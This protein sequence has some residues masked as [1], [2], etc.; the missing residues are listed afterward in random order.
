M[1]ANRKWSRSWDETVLYW[2]ITRAG[3]SY[4]SSKACYGWCKKFIILINIEFPLV[5]CTLGSSGYLVIKCSVKSFPFV[6]L[7]LMTGKSLEQIFL[8]DSCFW[9]CHC[10]VSYYATMP[11]CIIISNFHLCILNT[12]WLDADLEECFWKHWKVN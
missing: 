10:T 2:W 6:C 5:H 3:R 9:K 11:V 8:Q 4:L 1:E 12:G 7:S